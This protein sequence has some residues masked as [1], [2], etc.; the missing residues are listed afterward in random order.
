MGLADG[1][2]PP[3]CLPAGGA[4]RS[5]GGGA[6]RRPPPAATSSARGSSILR[7]LAPSSG[8]PDLSDPTASRGSAAP[9]SSRWAAGNRVPASNGGRDSPRVASLEISSIGRPRTAGPEAGSGGRARSG[10]DTGG[11]SGAGEPRGEGGPARPGAS[12]QV[13][14]SLPPFT[15]LPSPPVFILTPESSTSLSP[16]SRCKQQPMLDPVPTGGEG[17]GPRSSSGSGSGARGGGGPAGVAALPALR[18]GLAVLHAALHAGRG[19]R[20]RG[21]GGG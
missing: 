9:R 13:P 3:A 7:F 21:G 19:A 1:R 14:P 8:M 18:G 11:G 20:G 12:A 15:P 5:S 6:P 4:S 10:F 2:L 16:A 17:G